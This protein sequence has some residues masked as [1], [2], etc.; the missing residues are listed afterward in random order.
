MLSKGDIICGDDQ[1]FAP[2]RSTV[3]GCINDR[4]NRPSSIVKTAVSA[5]RNRLNC[6]VSVDSPIAVGDDLTERA[7]ATLGHSIESAGADFALVADRRIAAVFG[8]EFGRVSRQS[9]QGL[10]FTNIDKRARPS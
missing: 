5:A 10:A 3:R 1:A 9:S 2:S 8:G 4:E 6:A 7:S